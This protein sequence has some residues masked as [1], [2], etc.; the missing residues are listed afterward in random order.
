MLVQLTTQLANISD[1]NCYVH[2]LDPVSEYTHGYFSGISPQPSRCI[3]RQEGSSDGQVPGILLK[4]SP[5]GRMRELLT[6]I[7]NRLQSMTGPEEDI[8]GGRTTGSGWKDSRSRG[9]T[10][11]HKLPSIQGNGL[12]RTRDNGK[13]KD[14]DIR[15][16]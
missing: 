10:T 16:Q 3:Q 8:S 14:N 13:R 9:T 2:E 11:L 12:F 15:L 5:L 4:Y 1:R 6:V 7:T